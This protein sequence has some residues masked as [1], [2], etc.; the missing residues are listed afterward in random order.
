[1][2]PQL[3]DTVVIYKNNKNTAVKPAGNIAEWPDEALYN[4]LVREDDTQGKYALVEAIQR[5]GQEP[6]PQTHPISDVV[7]YVM[8]G[9]MTFSVDGQTIAAPAGA[10]VF[11]SK[12]HTYSFTVK[13]EMANTLILFSPAISQEYY[14][15]LRR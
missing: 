13:T 11:I 6:Y 10:N 9:E 15:M 14:H 8:A 2:L 4:F 12:G 7:F 5:Q 3:Q 1:M